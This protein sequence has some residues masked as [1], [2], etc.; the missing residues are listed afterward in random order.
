MYEIG[1]FLYN[2]P[3]EIEKYEMPVYN[4]FYIPALICLILITFA[5]DLF[6][7]A[8]NLVT[9]FN[10][11]Y[12]LISLTPIAV[13]TIGMYTKNIDFT[14]SL[15]GVIIFCF[16]LTTIFPFFGKVKF[17]QGYV[18]GCTFI[19][20]Y[21]MIVK[22][23]KY[24]LLIVGAII[25]TSLIY[26]QLSDTRTM[27]LRVLLYPTLFIAFSMIKKSTFLKV[28]LLVIASTC[29]YIFVTNLTEVLEIYKEITGVKDFDTEDTRA[30]LYEE[31]FLDLNPL[32]VMFGKGFMGTYFSEYFLVLLSSGNDSGD[33]YE[34]FSVEVGYLQLILKIGFIG[35]CLYIGPLL[36]SALKGLFQHYEQPQIFAISVFII[37]ELFL[38][39]IEL[40]QIGRAHV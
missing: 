37:T 38:M 27:A 39:F 35:Y 4:N 16:L 8:L 5:R 14:P 12:G 17:Y 33:F 15:F 28:L 13:Y 32:E 10:N 26:S 36:Y 25:L 20:L 11:P 31:V 9:L 22:D 21:L 18:C 24:N 1:Y 2:K 40:M 3:E 23:G 30:F 6:N 7:P 29:L 19:P 34:R